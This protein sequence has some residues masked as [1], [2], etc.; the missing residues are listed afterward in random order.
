MLS[1][2]AWVTCAQV[3]TGKHVGDLERKLLA[4]WCHFNDF[5]KVKLGCWV[6]FTL[7][8]QH[9]FEALV[10]FGAVQCFTIAQTVE[11]KA[12]QGLANTTWVECA[13]AFTSICIEQS[14]TYRCVR[15]C[16]GGKP[17]FVPKDL[18]KGF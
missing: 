6:L 16:E 4:P 7:H 3:A 9:V 13:G 2:S 1:L 17:Y 15:A 12:F 10:I 18:T 14:L 11:L 8:N 5:E